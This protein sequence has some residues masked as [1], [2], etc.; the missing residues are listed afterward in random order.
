MPAPTRR[1][2]ADLPGGRRPVVAVL[3]TGIGEH[4][5]LP[6]GD[7]A[8]GD[9]VVQVAPE[10]QQLLAEHET[11]F[12][13]TTGDVVNPL[14]S[15]YEVRD[16]IDP[17]LGLT[18]SHSGHGTFVT[19]LVHQTCPDARVLMLRILHTDGVATEGSLLLAL[20]WLRHRVRTALD[21]GDPTG[22]VDVVSLSLGF[23]PE[24]GEAA[25]VR[26]LA[27]A[28]ARLT[29]LGVVVVAAAG[30]DATTRPFQPAALGHG[31][32]ASAGGNELLS[33]VG[34]LNASG[35]TTA[36]FS[37]HGDWITRRAPGNALVSTV[38]LWQG[39]AG[40]AL[41]LP[42]GGPGGTHVRST[43]D[44][45]DLT[46]GFA[47][48]AGTSFA[49]PVIAGLVASGFAASAENSDRCARARQALSVC[50]QVLSQR[51]WA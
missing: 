14:S 17:L 26:Q 39:S 41:S 50:D 11:A 33:A 12:A 37:N 25:D 29:D 7:P 46:T 23:Y 47:V 20:E 9:P 13:A 15:P 3:D 34:A 30:N 51:Q 4:P 45:D 16:E 2:A 19:G 10:F 32:G 43:P 44:S 8:T 21:T 31:T 48:W 38:P 42:D 27:D 6:I 24:Q 49:T 18:D 35:H 40:P 28:V 36:A 22:L 1:P 5:W